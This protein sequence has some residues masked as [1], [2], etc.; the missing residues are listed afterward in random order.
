MEKDLKT[1]NI[2][3][4]S[5]IYIGTCFLLA[6]VQ[7]GEE[8][9]FEYSTRLAQQAITATIVMGFSAV[10]SN[11]LPNSVKHPLV[12]FRFQNVLSGHRC[13]RICKRDPRLPENHLERRWPELYAQNMKE[14]EQ[15]SYWYKEIYLPVR[16]CL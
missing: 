9:V 3:P 10:L 12:Y 11:L 1:Q 15:N 4:L 13:K 7:W 16:G 5:A 14:S 6:L 8:D 2:L